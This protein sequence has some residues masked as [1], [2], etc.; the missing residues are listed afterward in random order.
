[1]ST[2]AFQPDADRYYAEGYWRAGDLWDDFAACARE[3]RSKTA[4]H[5]GDDVVSYEQLPRA[6]VSF[7]AEPS[8]RGGR[9]GD[10][11][12]LL[13]RTSVKAAIGLLGCFHRGAV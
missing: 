2:L 3:H 5:A 12:L 11:V 4:L 6:A 13:G 8:A 9:A 10:V 1:M 7:S